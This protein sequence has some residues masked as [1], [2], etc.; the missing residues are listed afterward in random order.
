LDSP[1]HIFVSSF[2]ANIQILS[3]CPAAKPRGK[4]SNLFKNQFFAWLVSPLK[5]GKIGNNEIQNALS[6]PAS[7]PVGPQ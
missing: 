7:P 3:V 6:L 4:H 1:F 5:G 2:F